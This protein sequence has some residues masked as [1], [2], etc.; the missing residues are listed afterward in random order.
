MQ[1]VS[2][3]K[4]TPTEREKEETLGMVGFGANNNELDDEAKPKIGDET[5][6]CCRSGLIIEITTET[7]SRGV[8]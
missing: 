7:C 8:S 6:C 2:S 5:V 4:S 1:L 3:A